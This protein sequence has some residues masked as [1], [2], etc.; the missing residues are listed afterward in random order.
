MQCAQPYLCLQDAPVGRM[1]EMLRGSELR[2]QGMGGSLRG[3]G[4][5]R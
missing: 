3:C 1:S 5:Y 2:L 4:L